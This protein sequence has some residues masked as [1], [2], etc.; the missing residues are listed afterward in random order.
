MTVLLIGGVAFVSTALW[1]V[2]PRLLESGW[3]RMRV[4][5]AGPAAPLVFV[6]LQAAQVVLAPIPGQL[7]A[8]VGGYLFGAALGTFYSMV[9]VT[10]GSTVVFLASRRYGRPFVT[11]VLEPTT[12]ERFDGFVDAYGSAGLFVAFLLPAF[13][14]DAL[15]VLAGLTEIGYRRF[16][17]LLV[18]GRTPTFLIAATAGTSLAE[19]RLTWA[20]SMVAALTLLTA[21]VCRYRS[22]ISSRLDA[23]SGLTG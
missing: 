4:E 7:L 12:L 1:W 2:E 19:G 22:R 3:V 15:C 10:L 8:G 13:P 21:L 16:L 20:I 17:V 23:L 5:A 6:S 11:R 18:V 9:G 14:D